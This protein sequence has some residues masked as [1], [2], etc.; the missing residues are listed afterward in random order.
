MIRA[1]IE[2]ILELAALGAFVGFIFVIA[3]AIGG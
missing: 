2:D 3:I 1:M